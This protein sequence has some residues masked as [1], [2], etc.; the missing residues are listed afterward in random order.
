MK[1]SHII[2]GVKMPNSQSIPN[3]NYTIGFEFELYVMDKATHV[4]YEIEDDDGNIE[5]VFGDPYDDENYETEDDYD[6]IHDANVEFDNA[7]YEYFTSTEK[8]I[9]WWD[10]HGASETDILSLI[11]DNDI[12]PRFGYADKDHE[13]V[14]T[15][16]NES[17]NVEVEY[18]STWDE[19]KQYFDI[20]E[21][22]MMNEYVEEEF[23]DAVQED[24]QESF[25]NWWGQYG[26]TYNKPRT[27][28]TYVKDIISST[29]GSAGNFP[30]KTDWA[31]I[32]D[33]TGGVEAEIVTPVFPD[34]A[35][36]IRHMRKVF[37][38]I[39]D[40]K[41]LITSSAC[42]LHVNIGTWKGSEYK[43]ID[44][45][46]FLVAYRGEYALKQF[47]RE[48]NKEY[49]EDKLPTIIN[50]LL[51]NKFDTNYK[52]SIDEIN[53][54]VISQS[55]KMSA[56]NLSK[57]KTFGYI[58][59]RAP[60][61]AGYENKAQEMIVQ[62]GRV[63]KAINIASNPNLFRKEYITALHSIAAK[64]NPDDRYTEPFDLYL[65]AHNVDRQ[66][67][68]NDIMSI[69]ILLKNAHSNKLNTGYTVKVNNDMIARI[70]SILKYAPDSRYLQS[71]RKAIKDDPT[72]KNTYIIR[73][74]L[75]NF[76]QFREEQNEN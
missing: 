31:V 75:K 76:P 48:T 7:N 9:E 39:Q 69:Q 51:T 19:F 24:M 13:Y 32:P 61:N 55:T 38:I 64:P 3:G 27:K 43:K 52:N 67:M 65:K 59:I 41:F 28:L 66:Y 23:K 22:V 12:Q 63:I 56:V 30:N 6:R 14:Y 50:A 58:E 36:G 71:I 45:L 42:G 8:F 44:W 4:S 60:G 21:K 29:F 2:E 49:T 47:A 17:T 74:L 35:T 1:I 40:D 72:L 26:D 25:S 37:Q 18:M 57:L 46:K 73:T 53:E 70:A 33:G 62:I 5:T 54:Y 20:T 10:N 68:H 16:S 15:D 11:E 34:I